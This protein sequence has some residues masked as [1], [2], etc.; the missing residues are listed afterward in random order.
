[1]THVPEWSHSSPHSYG[2]KDR[3][4][5]THFQLLGIRYASGLSQVRELQRATSTVFGEKLGLL[6]ED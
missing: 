2:P 4:R 3:Y 1:M 6:Y 5:R